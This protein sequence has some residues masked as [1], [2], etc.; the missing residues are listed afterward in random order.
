[1]CISP[2][3]PSFRIRTK[4]HFG[5]P[6]RSQI[7]CCFRSRVQLIKNPKVIAETTPDSGGHFEFH[8]LSAPAT[9]LVSASSPEFLA[10]S[11]SV[12][13]GA[14]ETKS[15]TLQFTQLSSVLQSITVVASSPSSMTPDPSQTVV[16]HDQVLDVTPAD[17]ALRF[18]FLAF[19]S[20]PHP[21]ASRLRNTLPPAL[22]EITANLSLCSSR[23]GHFLF[24]NNLPANAHG[25]GY[26]DPNF[27]I[28]S[29][30][31]AVT[32]DGGSFN[33]REG[34]HSIDLATTYVP[35]QRFDDF[36]QVTGDYRDLDL[37]AGWSPQNPETNAW[38][39]GEASYG[40][41]FLDRLEHRQQ[42][43]LNGYRLFKFGRHD[44]SLFGTAYYMASLCSWPH[45][46]ERQRSQRHHR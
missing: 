37:V 13:M 1:M 18:P 23:S 11:I 31:E 4:Y 43:K 41:G 32:I 22:P 9:Y 21:A 30:I 14:S 10:I 36:V 44:L 42:Y 16:V 8:N 6:S 33:V 46:S 20:K 35:R 29:T 39:S 2:L 12:A 24:P 5:Y 25:N 3:L 26:A 38:L 15:I 45:S 34:N 19:P 7:V 17:P 27:L 40:N 28:A